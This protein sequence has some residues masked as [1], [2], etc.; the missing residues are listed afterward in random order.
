MINLLT[1]VYLPSSYKRIKFSRRYPRTVWSHIHLSGPYAPGAETVALD[2]RVLDDE[3]NELA[4]IERY[5]MKKVS[6][7]RPA[8]APTR[9]VAD[10]LASRPKDILPDEGASALDRIL[11]APFLPQVIVSTSD[12]YK[13]I[14]EEKP[15][16]KAVES[17]EEAGAA[18]PAAGY[19]RPS[20]STPYEEPANEIEKAIA[21][22]WQGILGIDRIGAND[23]FTE[24]GGNSLLVVQ[25]VA[26]MADTFQIDLPMEAFYQNPTVGALAD[27]VVEQLVS[28]ASTDTLE[29]LV[30][31]LEGSYVGP[32]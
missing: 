24:L 16:A 12:F 1:T 2:V 22:I 32:S 26:N 20:L 31:S 15:A 9:R 21:A 25:T 13:L 10:K 4:T 7:A 8:A 29:G 28:M 18:K 14:E 5:T 11:G 3:G 23:D 6:A 17:T 30:S 27:V 19:S